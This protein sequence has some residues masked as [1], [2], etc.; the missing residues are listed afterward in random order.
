LGEEVI[1]GNRF[2]EALEC[3]EKK[4]NANDLSLHKLNQSQL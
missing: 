4:A 1:A 2:A 3:K